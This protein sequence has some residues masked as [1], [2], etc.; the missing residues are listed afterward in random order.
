VG[1]LQFALT[2]INFNP[3][4]GLAADLVIAEVEELVPTGVISPEHVQFPGA[5]VDYVVIGGRSK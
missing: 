2:A 3:M 1:N 5:L 4:M